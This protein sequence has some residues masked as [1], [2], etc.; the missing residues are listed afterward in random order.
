MS[1]TRSRYIWLS[2]AQV[3]C[4]LLTFPAFFSVVSFLAA[5]TPEQALDKGQKPLPAGWSA[6]VMNHGEYYHWWTIS[7]RP[8]FFAF[9]LGALIG[10]LAFIYGSL[11]WIWKKKR[12][13]GK[14]RSK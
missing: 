13:A 4:C 7:Q 1:E 8:V 2:V 12:I 14:G 6:G 9:S 3:L 10:A 5:E 11:F